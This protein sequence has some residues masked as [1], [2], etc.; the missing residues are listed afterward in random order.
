MVRLEVVV[1]EGVGEEGPLLEVA[2]LCVAGSHVLQEAERVAGEGVLVRPEVLAGQGGGESGEEE[3][4]RR[5]GVRQAWL[6][7]RGRSHGGSGGAVGCCGAGGAWCG[8]LVLLVLVAAVLGVLLGAGLCMQGSFP[9]IAF[10]LRALSACSFQS[11]LVAPVVS[12]QCCVGFP[13]PGIGMAAVCRAC[14]SSGSEASG[15]GVPERG[16]GCSLSAAGPAARS[17]L[18]N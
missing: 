16:L 9:F 3:Q 6:C 5:G 11:G 18:C 2:G 4:E 8:G 7:G 13:V 17:V 10:R 15:S 12:G 14:E 1:E